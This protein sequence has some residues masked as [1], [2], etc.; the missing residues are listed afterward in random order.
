MKACRALLGAAGFLVMLAAPASAQHAGHAAQ[1]LSPAVPTTDAALASA[2]LAPAGTVELG[3]PVMDRM[4]FVHGILDQLEGRTDGRA[5]ELRWS[6][7]GWIGTDYDR[8]WIKTEGMRARDGSV[9]DNRNEF[10]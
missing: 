6:G 9:E 3:H 2:P 5:P 7:Q 10:L 4:I 8:F 1:G